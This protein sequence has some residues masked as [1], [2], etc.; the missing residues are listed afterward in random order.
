MLYYDLSELYMISR[1]R[2]KFYGIARVVAEV[3]HDVYMAAPDTV[4]VIYD[5][6]RRSFLKVSPCFG[7]ASDNG[8]ISLGLPEAFIPKPLRPFKTTRRAPGRLLAGIRNFFT[9]MSNIARAPDLP[10]GVE[11]VELR[12]GVLFSA[13][14]PQLVAQMVRKLKRQR[15][16]SRLHV[17]L[18]DAIPLYEYT[19]QPTASAMDFRHN[20][21]LII[22]F[23]DQIIANSEFTRQD[24]VRF[25]EEG[26]LPPLPRIQVVPLAQQ[27]RCETDE[28]VSVPVP[29]RPYIVGVGV[30][31]GRKNLDVI[32]RAQEIMLARNEEPPLMLFCG[33]V[34]NSMRRTLQSGAWP[35]A[36][37][38]L[39]LIDSPSQATLNHLLKHAVAAVVPSKLE[40]WGLP[41][42]EALW[43][44]VP[45]VTART[46]SLTEVGQD[47][48]IYF[49]PDDAE[50]LADILSRLMTDDD[51]K[52]SVRQ[53]IEG[54]HGSLRTWN[55]VAH[56][57]LAAVRGPSAVS[58]PGDISLRAARAQVAA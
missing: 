24:L 31:L 10:E 27:T 50:E 6:S 56:G 32:L 4:F 53:R 26:L 45:P 14:R 39:Q 25:A 54:R 16:A 48:A 13:S 36:R 35:T 58:A 33:A 22:S 1:G 42:G 7:A 5:E 18:H 3:A 29:A 2:L 37:E 11:K 9:R 46:S 19:G 38:H 43:L 34:R 44:G 28:A 49:D 52:R 40:G 41:V 30:T 23:A 47:L 51:Y 57:I 15:S 17:M 55:C 12:D 20:N 8:L 21:A